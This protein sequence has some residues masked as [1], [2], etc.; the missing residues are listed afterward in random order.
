MQTSQNIS[1]TNG[2]QGNYIS[3]KIKEQENGETRVSA[4]PTP[5][6]PT[7]Q[8]TP[9]PSTPKPPKTLQEGWDTMIGL[10]P[11]SPPY[12]S[13][14][15]WEVRESHTVVS[16][17]ACTDDGCQVHFT[18]KNRSGYF[19]QDRSKSVPSQPQSKKILEREQHQ[20]AIAW[21]ECYKDKC[22]VHMQEKIRVG[23]YHQKDG[24]RKPLSTW[25][26][27]HPNPESQRKWGFLAQGIPLERNARAWKAEP[28]RAQSRREGSEKNSTGGR[29][30]ATTDP[31]ASE[32]QGATHKG[33]RTRSERH[34][35]LRHNN[36]TISC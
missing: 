1:S 22:L 20:R 4:S 31:E 3:I 24:V 2:T 32:R 25:H 17:T 21:D 6:S 23:Y 34:S 5:Q 15:E 33:R 35:R 13:P 28:R 14:R 19:L 16:W 18:D 29:G 11:S 26:K 10:P 7:E 9:R 8:T 27:R 30:H 12:R 36:G